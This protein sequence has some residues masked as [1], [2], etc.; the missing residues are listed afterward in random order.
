MPQSINTNIISMITQRNLVDPRKRRDI[1]RR[2][3]VTGSETGGIEGLAI[4]C[5]FFVRELANPT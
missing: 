1:L 2:L 5:R 3:Q 4:E